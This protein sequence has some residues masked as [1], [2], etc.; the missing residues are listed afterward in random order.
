MSSL[1]VT[2]WLVFFVAALAS[3]S[4]ANMHYRR[5]IRDV[6]E[7]LEENDKKFSPFAIV[8][9]Q[10]PLLEESYTKLIPEGK[11][12]RRY[13]KS[14]KIFWAFG[15]LFLLVFILPL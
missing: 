13:R 8:A 1:Q 10:M 3:G 5:M 12:L 6:N 4:V 7:R 15:I 9:F 14:M 11:L 2:L